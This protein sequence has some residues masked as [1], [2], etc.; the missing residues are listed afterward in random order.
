MV[1]AVA[2]GHLTNLVQGREALR[3]S[4]EYRSYAPTQSGAW[5]QAFSRYKSIVARGRTPEPAPA[6]A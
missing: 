6:H 3:Q 5:Q 2:T 1:Q 4:V